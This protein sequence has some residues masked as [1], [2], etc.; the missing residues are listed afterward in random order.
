MIENFDRMSLE[1]K[2]AQQ[3][4]EYIEG[5]IS[6]VLDELKLEMMLSTYDLL[7]IFEKIKIRL[8]CVTRL[9]NPVYE[10]TVMAIPD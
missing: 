6:E 8:H 2:Q 7:E 4:S 10:I 9:A 5:Q 1:I 3:L